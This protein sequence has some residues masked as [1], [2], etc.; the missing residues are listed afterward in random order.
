MTG[1]VETPGD[2]A[3]LESRL[4]LADWRRR[5]SELYAEVRSRAHADPAAAH[6]FWVAE[7]EALY[8]DHAQS[9][10][11]PERRAAFRARHWPYDPAMHFEV[12]VRP[13]APRATGGLALAL[14]EGDGAALDFSPIGRVT[15]PVPDGERDLTLFWM[16][17]YTGGLFLPFRDATNG[18][19][20]YGAGRYAVDAAKSADL[21]GD[22]ARGTIVLDFNFA[23]QPSC[24]WDPRWACP[25]APPE[26]RL[27]IPVRAGEQ[28][29]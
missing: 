21:G 13:P 2:A 28:L 3:D 22:V 16:A 19:E 29:G 26:N 17:G 23:Y 20:T 8:R 7:R 9:P 10:L 25:L 11:P 6:A 1:E 4:S 24:A 5:V 12:A 14:P 27:D 15:V 18:Q